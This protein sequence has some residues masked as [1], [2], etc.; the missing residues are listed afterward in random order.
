MEKSINNE[1]Y[2]ENG[3][4]DNTEEG[5]SP[6]FEELKQTVKNGLRK[7]VVVAIGECGLDYDK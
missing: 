4:K 5:Y 7:G 3:E 6:Y 1:Y 2:N